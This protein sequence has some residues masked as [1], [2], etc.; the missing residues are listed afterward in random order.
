MHTRGNRMFTFARKP[1]PVQ[2]T[3]LAYCSTTGLE[4]IDYRLS[5][6]Y[7][8][9]YYSNE[10]YYSERAL[11]LKSYWCYPSPQPPPC[12]FP[13]VPGEGNEAEKPDGFITFGCLNDFSKVSDLSLSMWTQILRTL[14]SSRL[15]IHALPGRHR[16]RVT[17]AMAGVDHSRVEFVGRLPM[18]E[19]FRQYQRI[20]IALDPTPWPGGT[21]TC[22]ALWMG[23]PVV[24]MMGKTAVSRGG[25][26]ILSQ[27]GHPELVARDPAQYV[28]IATSLAQ[29]KLRLAEFRQTLR[30]A[31]LRSPLMDAIGFTRDFESI[32]RAMWRSY[33]GGVQPK[34]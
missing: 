18:G 3:Y 28:H 14:P 31:M 33:L 5:D 2:V 26:S 34:C 1:A 22:D 13:G 7:L 10:R 12:P 21:T 11:R 32:L 4:T 23:V 24:S 25:L 16:N 19:Y 15:V 30:E 27:I 9:P 20:D 6:S 8:D 29:D 17:K